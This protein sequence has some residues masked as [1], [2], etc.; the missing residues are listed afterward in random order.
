MSDTNKVLWYFWYN[1]PALQKDK[2]WRGSLKSTGDIVGF[3]GLLLS[4]FG[5]LRES[6]S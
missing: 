4:T 1:A 6:A 2:A 3:I 5:F